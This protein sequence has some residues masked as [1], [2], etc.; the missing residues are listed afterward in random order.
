MIREPAV[1][2]SP[3]S[4]YTPNSAPSTAAPR[5]ASAKTTHGDLPPSSIDRPLSPSAAVRMMV[6]PVAVSPVKEISGTS[7]C[8]ARAAPAV[9]PMP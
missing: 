2:R 9:S 6:R 8:P 5:S 3:L 7:G 4:E 1:H